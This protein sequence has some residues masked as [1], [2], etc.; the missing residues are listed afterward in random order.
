M[1]RRIVS[2]LVVAVAILVPVSV[3]AVIMGA[4][5]QYVG[6]PVIPLGKN[7]SWDDRSVYSARVV[8]DGAGYR[9]WYAASGSNNSCAKIGYAIS[10]DGL[11]WKK[12]FA[13]PVLEPGVGLGVG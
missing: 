4:W 7:G 13:T 11:T 10:A 9:M 2:A 6:N 3:L 12:P 8:Y 5:L 1:K